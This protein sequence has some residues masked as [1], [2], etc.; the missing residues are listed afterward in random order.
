MSS[1][2]TST[3]WK[4]EGTT[5]Y[6]LESIGYRKGVERFQNRFYVNVQAGPQTPYEEV[7][8]N[9]RL[10][11]VAPDMK[12]ML[13]ELLGLLVVFSKEVNWGA[14]ALSADT[15]DKINRLPGAANALVAQIE[16]K[17]VAGR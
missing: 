10:I 6:S 17:D 12:Q 7:E 3:P 1:R 11:V 16:G 8:A 9:A 14:S 4:R 2:H 13:G 5:I 15:I